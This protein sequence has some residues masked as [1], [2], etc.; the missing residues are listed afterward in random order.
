MKKPVTVTIT[1]AAGNI[2]YALALRR[3]KCSAQINRST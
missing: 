1:G 2:G 3:V